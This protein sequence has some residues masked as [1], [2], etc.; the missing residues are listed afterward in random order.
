MTTI[1]NYIPQRR[2]EHTVKPDPIE[3]EKPYTISEFDEVF[4]NN[5]GR[6]LSPSEV[7]QQDL[8]KARK[9]K[10]KDSDMM[11]DLVNKSNRILMSVSTHSFPFNFFPST[12]NIEEKR[13]TIITRRFLSSDVHSIDIRNI[14]NVFINISIFYSQLTIISKTYAENEIRLSGI[15]TKEAVLARRIIEG[16]RVFE[17]NKIDTHGYSKLDLISKL[18][19]L[20]KTEIVQ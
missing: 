8:L 15:R 9:K 20:S 3:K 19:E 16:L 17:Q 7:E 14:T 6:Y 5:P 1:F 10:T 13:I 12:L 4:D 18:E 2:S 11:A